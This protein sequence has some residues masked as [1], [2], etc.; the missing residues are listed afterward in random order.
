[1]QRPRLFTALLLSACLLLASGCSLVGFGYRQADTLAAWKADE[2]FDL[3]PRQKDEFRKRFDAFYTWHRYEQLPDYVAFLTAA[4]DRMQRQVTRQDADWLLDGAR[5][6]YEIMVRHAAPDAAALLATLT[7]QQIQHLQQRWE[8]DNRRISRE[9]R[10]EASVEDRKRARARRVLSQVRDWTGSLSH[11]QED[12]IT[13][14]ADKL[15]QIERL[16]YQDRLR[17]QREFLQL[18]ET[19]TQKDFPDRLR[20]WMV[21]W[22]AGRTAE[23]DKAWHNAL[24]QRVQ[25]FLNVER[26]LTTEQRA[27]VQQRLQKYID[28]FRTL[29][30]RQ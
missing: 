1:M 7:P 10:L 15:P 30:H 26:M 25:L 28:E 29:S 16:R 2:Y 21:N 8:R 27:T 20:D 11:E 5:R 13:A 23:Y 3:E 22:D 4:R 19:R 24:D 18:L 17:R 14:M 12:A 9:Q 6:R